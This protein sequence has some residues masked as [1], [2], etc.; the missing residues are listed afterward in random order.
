M[1]ER[2]QGPEMQTCWNSYYGTG[3]TTPV[4]RVSK[5]VST[6]PELHIPSL[7]SSLDK[8]L[9]DS[10]PQVL[11]S[12]PSCNN[13]SLKHAQLIALKNVVWASNQSVSFRVEPGFV[14]RLGF[15]VSISPTLAWATNTGV[16]MLSKALAEGAASEHISSDMPQS[17][18]LKYN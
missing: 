18:G 13:T 14:V 10:V 2:F 5:H 6:I 17:Q 12:N 9:S 15:R 8:M 3:S 4:I 11:N 7:M 1:D 16:A